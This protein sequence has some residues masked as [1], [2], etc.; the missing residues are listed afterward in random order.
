MVLSLGDPVGARTMLEHTPGVRQSAAL[1]QVAAEADL[2][3]GREDEACGLGDNLVAG[4]DGPYWRRLRVYCLLKAGDKPGAQLAYDLTAEQAKDDI[5]KRLMSAA[6]A[7]TPPGEVSLRNGIEY[8]ISRRLQLDLA[9][10]MDKAWAPIVT[11]VAMDPSA[12]AL[13]MAGARSSCRR[14]EMAYSMPLRRDTSPGGV[15]ATAALIRR[16]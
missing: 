7:G 1:S 16:L 10:A 13:S 8:A 9:P 15:P 11:M 2:V 3:L 4:K 12:Q 5:Y 6:V 14:R